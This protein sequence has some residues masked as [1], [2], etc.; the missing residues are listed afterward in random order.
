MEGALLPRSNRKARA[1]RI[2]D[3]ANGG[4]PAALCLLCRAP[5]YSL[6]GLSGLAG[7]L[8][9]G[10]RA[11]RLRAKRVLIAG[12]LV[13]ALAIGTYLSSVGAANSMR[14]R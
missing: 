12:L 11:D 9:L 2:G 4:R 10:V 7:R 3:A 1:A 8:L 13:Q 5:I 6:E 14:C